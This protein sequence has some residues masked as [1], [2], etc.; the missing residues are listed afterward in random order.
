MNFRPCIDLHNGKVKQ[1]VGSSLSDGDSLP[2][3]NFESSYDSSYYAEM[4]KKDNLFGGHIIKLGPGNE[5]A[6]K[7]A[8]SAWPNGMQIGGGINSENA[9]E[10]LDYGA[11]HVI[12]TSYVFSDGLINYENLKKLAAA[13]GKERLVLDLSCKERDGE[14]FI[15]TDRW[16]K[17]TEV[18]ITPKTL[19]YFSKFCDELLIHA[20]SV[21]GKMM[22]P[23]LKLVKI[24]GDSW[25]IPVT[26]AGGITTIDDVKKIALTGQNR[27]DF[28]VGSALD[29]FGG[30]LKYS[31]VVKYCTS[32]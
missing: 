16:Q 8:L 1:I 2:D 3:T 17:W 32:L 25:F 4:Y 11:S 26:Y 22:G 15:V 18:K 28:T 5:D 29:I 27:V 20:A 30:K 12:V 14:Y 13:V 21:E 24:L 31:N 7:R 9:K 19:E 23:D 10:Y 6:A